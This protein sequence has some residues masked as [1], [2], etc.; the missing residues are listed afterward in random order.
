MINKEY[1]D[2]ISQYLDIGHDVLYLSEADCKESGVTVDE[3]IDLTEKAMVAYAT[4]RT[5]MPAKIGIHPVPGSLMHAMPAYLKDDYACGIKWGCQFPENRSKFPHLTNTVCNIVYNDPESGMP[6]AY[7]DATW[8][9]EIR[10]PAAACCSM[11]YLANTTTTTYGQFACG[12]QGKSQVKMV[13]KVLP[14]LKEIY[15]YDAYEPAMDALIEQCQ[16]VVNAKIIK[17]TNPEQVAKSAEVI[18]SSVAAPNTIIPLAFVKNEWIS[19]GQTLI[20]SDVHTTYEDAVFKRADIY[21]VD[22]IAQTK[23]LGEYG[24]Y[25]YGVPEIYCETGVVMAGL[26]P[27]RTSPDQLC[28]ANNVGLAAEDMMCAKAVFEAA[29]KNKI[30]VKLPLWR[31]SN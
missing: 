19:A 29:L 10:T 28:I 8:I 5:E 1:R 11:K 23:S 31:R 16:P 4:D 25:P 24:Y 18:G 7:M 6:M 13:E 2:W 26:K 15:I 9:T 30:G 12:I 27:G 3:I 20:C 22:S 17:C 21:V 14:K